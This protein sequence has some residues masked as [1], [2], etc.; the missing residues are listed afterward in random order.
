MRVGFCV[1]ENDLWKS[2]ADELR[3]AVGIEVVHGI[4]ECR[5]Q[6]D[7][8]SVLVANRLEPELFEEARALE[9]LFVPFVGI[10]HLP[11][12]LLTQRGVRVFNCHGNAFSVAERALA[13]VLAGFGRIVEYHND[14]RAGRWHGFWVGKGKEDFWDSIQGKHC[15]VLGTGAIGQ[16]LALLLQAFSCPVAGFRRSASTEQLPGF[17]LV[18]NNLS[19]VLHGAE[20]VFVTLPLTDATKGLIGRHELAACRGAYLV[21]VGRGEVVDETALYEA[22]QDGTL[23][24]AALDVWYQYP[25]TGSEYGKP[26]HLPLDELPNVLLSPHVA[27]STHTAARQNILQT[28]ENVKRYLQTGAA[29]HQVD[30]S[31]Q[32]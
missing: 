10:N 14:L 29:L 25:P 1:P 26:S 8:F 9:A 7:T 6:I 11:A 21:N 28:A 30:L 18:S 20:I 32:Y 31:S 5:A 22:L 3:T 24:G 19:Q 4:E 16:S 12:E 17:N 15:A 27:G 23:A 13:L 2:A